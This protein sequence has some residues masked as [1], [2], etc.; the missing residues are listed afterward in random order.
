MTNISPLKVRSLD[1]QSSK[2]LSTLLQMVMRQTIDHFHRF[3]EVCTDVQNEQKMRRSLNS[4]FLGHPYGQLSIEQAYKIGVGK[5]WSLLRIHLQND[6]LSTF[7]PLPSLVR[8]F[9]PL[10]V[11]VV[12]LNITPYYVTRVTSD[13]Y[14]LEVNKNLCFSNP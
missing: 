4:I 6:L 9:F 14:V 8:D 12:L 2:F 7:T 5:E 11:Y 10:K 3:F 13:C 1:L